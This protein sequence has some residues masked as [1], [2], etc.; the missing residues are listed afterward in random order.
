[1][2]AM[3]NIRK[4]PQPKSLTKFLKMTDPKPTF[5]G[6]DEY[7]ER[8]LKKSL[9]RE[10][11]GICCYCMSPLELEP[12]KCVIEHWQPKGRKK[13]PHRQLDYRNLMLSCTGGAIHDKNTKIKRRSAGMSGRTKKAQREWMVHCDHAKGEREL[14]FSPVEHSIED[15]FAYDG[16]GMIRYERDAGFNR[17]LELVLNLN[18]KYLCEQRVEALET[19]RQLLVKRGHLGKREWL[20]LREVYTRPGAC[21]CFKPFCM[22]IVYYIDKKLRQFH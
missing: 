1:M 17:Q 18:Q 5:L 11:G 12:G 9:Y 20:R 10:Q 2:T 19:F 15:G 7:T 16:K 4:S 3:R 13:Y 6:M 22:V 8:D 21:G 14:K